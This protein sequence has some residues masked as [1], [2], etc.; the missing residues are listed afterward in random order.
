MATR[1]AAKEIL[2]LI[3]IANVMGLDQSVIQL[4]YDIHN[5]IYLT[6]NQVYRTNIDVCVCVWRLFQSFHKDNQLKWRLDKYFMVIS[7]MINILWLEQGLKLR[8]LR[9]IGSPTGEPSNGLIGKPN[10]DSTGG[11]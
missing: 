4:H 5:I 7:V 9:P 10:N 2:W 1:E 8:Y 11:S 3:G 6:K